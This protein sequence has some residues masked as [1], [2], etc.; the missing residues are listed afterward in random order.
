M[1][2]AAK[3][4][5]KALTSALD[6]VIKA[7]SSAP[8]A[9]LVPCRRALVHTLRQTG[10][11]EAISSITDLLCGMDSFVQIMDDGA[12]ITEWAG[13]LR[14]WLADTRGRATSLELEKVCR[15]AA[16]TFQ[17]LDAGVAALLSSD[18]VQGL[19][20]Q[21]ASVVHTCERKEPCMIAAIANMYLLKMAHGD[22]PPAAAAAAI[23]RSIH[24][25]AGAVAT[26]TTEHG[27]LPVPSVRGSNSVAALSVYRSL[28]SVLTPAVLA[29][30]LPGR[31][32]PAPPRG[33]TSI[34]M[35]CFGE[36]TALIRSS[37][38]AA[39][40]FLA[41]S[42]LVLWF[43]TAHV[44]AK[45]APAEFSGVLDFTVLSSHAD[46]GT[47][48]P[49]AP[50]QSAGQA[51]YHD[52]MAIIWDNLEHP[53]AEIRSMIRDTF[54]GLLDV[55]ET[56]GAWL[57][58]QSDAPAAAAG[59]DEALALQLLRTP[60]HLKGRYALLCDVTKRL[61]FEKTMS[62]SSSLPD[63][64]FKCFGVSA[65]SQAAAR[66]Y[67]E[68]SKTAA[69]EWQRGL[70]GPPGKNKGGKK[71]KKKK[72]ANGAGGADQAVNEAQLASQWG[73]VWLD[74]V[75]KS[76]TDD[77]RLLRYHVATYCLPET[78][79]WF[80]GA[81]H[82]LVRK[83]LAA[84]DTQAAP[85]RTRLLNAL[86]VTL[87][88]ARKLGLI[89][90]ESIGDAAAAAAADASSSIC[91]S[92]ELVLEALSHPDT[93][94]QLEA[95]AF[96]CCDLRTTTEVSPLESRLFRHFVA[97]NL[98]IWETSVRQQFHICLKSLLGR[99]CE[100][101]LSH[102]RASAIAGRKLEKLDETGD[103]DSPACLAAIDDMDAAD[104]AAARTG[105]AM[106]Q[107]VCWLEALCLAS[108]YPGAT[109]PRTITAIKSLDALFAWVSRV[110]KN[111]P[112]DDMP[113]GFPDLFSQRNATILM[114]SL[115]N[116]R[117]DV[118]SIA[119]A[120]LL[121]HFAGRM[122]RRRVTHAA[123]L[124]AA[125]ERAANGAREIVVGARLK[126]SETGADLFQ[127]VFG[128]YVENAGVYFEVAGDSGALVAKSC[129]D[130][131]AA[132]APPSDG[133][134]HFVELL[135]SMIEK[136]LE[137]CRL[138]LADA[139]RNAVIHGVVLT[140]RRVWALAVPHQSPRA[141]SPAW[142]AVAARAVEL[143]MEVGSFALSLLVVDPDSFG[144]SSSF[145]N[146]TTTALDT[147]LAEFSTD[148]GAAVGPGGAAVGPGGAEPTSAGAADAGSPPPVDQSSSRDFVL[149]L[150]WR[151][152][153]EVS[154]F[155]GAV[156]QPL[157][158]AGE[159]PG[160][161]AIG[162]P[163]LARIGD[164]FRQVLVSCR[165]KGVIE[166]CAI[167]FGEFCQRLSRCACDEVY[168]LPVKWLDSS[169]VAMAT[170]T[171]VSITRRSA[172]LPYIIQGII[173][174]TQRSSTIE[175]AFNGL[176]QLA[177]KPVDNTWEETNDLPQV[178][179][180]HTLN[181][182]FRNSGLREA[183]QPF[184]EEA[185]LLAIRGFAASDWAIANAAMMLFGTLA[186]RMLG[187]KRV[188]DTTASDNA[189]TVREFA[190]R[191]SKLYVAKTGLMPWRHHG[192]TCC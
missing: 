125:A 108:M 133:A 26:A 72:G 28:L 161:L 24:T 124:V 89:S 17:R 174:T 118:R 104:E 186:Q 41:Y 13:V 159:Q 45:K 111:V 75:V 191:Y 130:P 58:K 61:G 59:L 140:L 22:L 5:R 190:S 67:A 107:T 87:R 105:D 85:D 109:Y 74:V 92:D 137:A 158:L 91:I 153:K 184:I 29:A 171:F 20:G 36:I 138:K 8:A 44:L 31:S 94:V 120:L 14:A 69:K 166:T 97:S 39:V 90:S 12:I 96:V 50:R 122:Q 65:L 80:P 115:I 101:W 15:A 127:V 34:L 25:E 78:L 163:T 37:K 10:S 114:D 178:R 55:L 43:K 42:S 141:T 121:Q 1:L 62:L 177:S 189:I 82:G 84:L 18:P 71:A 142:V 170:E 136:H 56:Q 192:D 63:E 147:A 157:S 128:M 77:N 167:G 146:M 132:G 73:A 48:A 126:E 164:W 9:F 162:A 116:S 156:V 149:A 60:W 106:V 180:M 134:L 165:H 143:L 188:S 68:L 179:A 76:L 93:D 23:D 160:P 66:L 123:E 64:I 2:G 145:A 185:A 27:A 95:L 3:Q 172:G 30:P 16:A 83:C 49:A 110:P 53:V 129:H 100:A 151:A 21:L 183:S 32:A 135:L 38:A 52:V 35:L 79:K 6:A 139:S 86:F 33:P 181:V 144:G 88:S 7:H 112:E 117:D 11:V 152:L 103:H 148:H 51:V 98:N 19:A 46:K 175:A 54:E 81:M 150:S 57:A 102:Y 154:M 187:F 169:L 47:D 176:L 168:S 70:S 155:L 40:S 113:E 119:S 4:A 131:E 99:M 182:V 173:T